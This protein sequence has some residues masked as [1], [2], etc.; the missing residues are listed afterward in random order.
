MCMQFSVNLT[1]PLRHISVLGSEPN[2]PQNGDIIYDKNC[3]SKY[4]SAS[5]NILVKES[6]QLP[7][8]AYIFRITNFESILEV[9]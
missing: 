5:F 1:L 8:C 3:T 2:Y 4:A 9:T 6:K 7:I